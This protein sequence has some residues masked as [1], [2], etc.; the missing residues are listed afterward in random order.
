MIF[1][2]HAH[3]YPKQLRENGDL[4][5]LKRLMEE[6]GIVKCVAFAPFSEKYAE[7]G[8]DINHNVWLSRQI[9]DDKAF[10]GFGTID[11]QREDL[12]DQVREVAALGFKGLKLHPPAQD[13]AILEERALTVYETAQDLNLFLSFHT[14]LHWSRLKHNLPI[15]YD[16]VAYNFPYLRFSMEHIGG[17][18]FFNDALAVI[19][20]N[21][22]GGTQPR[23]FAGWTSIAEDTGAWSLT[24]A[25]LEAVIAQ[26][27]E[28]KSIFGLDFPFKTAPDINSAIA[29]IRALNIT[30]SAKEKILGGN[31]E[32]EVG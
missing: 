18:S 3:V 10:V 2:N 8:A 23:V 21:K 31:L 25:Q 30:E 16:E 1:A 14:G 9:K 7:L 6:C 4:D 28:E 11:F 29:R 17:Y 13:F 32:R 5:A 19:A 27:G 24:D 26:T 12:V 22:R 15:Q 20:N